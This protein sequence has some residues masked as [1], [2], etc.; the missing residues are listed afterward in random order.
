MKRKKQEWAKKKNQLDGIKR[1]TDTVS[2]LVPSVPSRALIKQ[3][4][5]MDLFGFW[6]R[7]HCLVFDFRPVEVLSP[8]IFFFRFYL[9]FIFLP[10]FGDEEPRTC[11]VCYTAARHKD[12]RPLLRGET[13]CLC[14]YLIFF[15]FF[16]SLSLSISFSSSSLSCN[17][18]LLFSSARSLAQL[19][20]YNTE[21]HKQTSIGRDPDS[22]AM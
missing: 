8:F 6:G 9:F 15:F 12:S 21:I 10:Y 13:C 18:Y 7:L 19:A 5:E 22:K 17:C 11:H 14:F 2:I 1:T 20:Q 3:R 16:F 4:D